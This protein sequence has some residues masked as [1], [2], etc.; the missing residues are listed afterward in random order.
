MSVVRAPFTI[1]RLS[2]LCIRPREHY[3][4]VGKYLRALEKT[5]YVTSTW[6]S[7][8]PLPPQPA[9]VMP[10]YIGLPPSS[11]PSTP[12]FSPISFQ[13]SDAR[14]SK[15]RSPPPSP[16]VLNAIDPGGIP[17][18]AAALGM[19]KTLGLVDELDDPAPGHM[20]ERPT[21]LSAV[22]SVGE[23]SA[24]Q[25]LDDRFVKASDSENEG[26]TGA[27]GVLAAKRE[28]SMVLDDQD[29]DKEN[30]S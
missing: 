16:L 10:A 12:L 3:S 30:K 15:S 24:V 8:P 6:D 27:A 5:L 19:E 22:T 18:D 20:S 9:N 29:G 14:R 7:F 17:L 13:H 4:S 21:A 28:E 1:Q 26:T 23:R 11:I 25:S 2:D